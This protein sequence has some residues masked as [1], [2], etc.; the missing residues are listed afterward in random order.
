MPAGCA[1]VDIPC[2]RRDYVRG[3]ELFAATHSMHLS[4]ILVAGAQLELRR[5]EPC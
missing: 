3:G 2:I 5:R 1:A 4:D